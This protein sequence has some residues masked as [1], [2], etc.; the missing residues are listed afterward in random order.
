MT[1]QTTKRRGVTLL[2]LLVVISMIGIFAAVVTAR[3]GRSIFGEFGAR[4]LAREMSLD[5]LTC[6]RAAIATGDDHLL[7]FTLGGPAAL[8]TGGHA[9]QAGGVTVETFLKAA[10]IGQLDTGALQRI[11]ESTVALAEHEGFP[12][13]ARSITIRSD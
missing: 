8:P 12:A 9:R 6:Q 5:L 1:I 3:Y 2:E 13:H 7:D 4:A 10:A 11:A